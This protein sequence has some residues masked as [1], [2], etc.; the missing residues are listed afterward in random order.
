M[1]QD[2][3]ECNN[4]IRFTKEFYPSALYL[5]PQLKSSKVNLLHFGGVSATVLS[6][7]FACNSGQG[8]AAPWGFT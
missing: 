4:V 7:I 6:R 3:G 1:Q 5:S 8:V 2:I